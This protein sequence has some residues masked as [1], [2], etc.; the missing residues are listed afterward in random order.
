MYA[1]RIAEAGPMDVVLTRP[2][3]P[4]TMG[5]RNAFP[6]LAG[7]ASGTLDADRGRAAQPTRA[8]SRLP[9]RAAL[10]L[11]SGHLHQGLTAAA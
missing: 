7:A 6:D 3:H 1:G 5:L 2:S 9:V 10:P 11:R 4:Y 8:S